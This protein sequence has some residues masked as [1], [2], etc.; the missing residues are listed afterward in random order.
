MISQLSSTVCGSKATGH[1]PINHQAICRQAGT[2]LPNY[3]MEASSNSQIST[4]SCV[5]EFSLSTLRQL[6]KTTL[7]DLNEAASRLTNLS[8]ENSTLIK[9]V[10]EIKEFIKTS[11]QRQLAVEINYLVNANRILRFANNEKE[12]TIEF[13]KVY[14][15]QLINDCINHLTNTNIE[16]LRHL[17]PKKSTENEII[18][19]PLSALALVGVEK[20]DQMS[21][22]KNR[23]QDLQYQMGAL[24]M[25]YMT[26]S[27]SLHAISSQIQHLE[28][29]NQNLIGEINSL[30]KS[31][32]RNQNM[33]KLVALKIENTRLLILLSAKEPNLK[34]IQKRVGEYHIIYKNILSERTNES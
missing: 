16:V 21:F 3:F 26:L 31:Q 20:H 22:I 7:G 34:A 30:E 12:S 23:N 10:T 2:S 18:E 4:T 33:K 11:K 13:E 27:N 8:H 28:N 25:K 6:N 9:S 5:S 17:C 1:C 24:Q 14:L 32:A 29:Q 15:S 19:D